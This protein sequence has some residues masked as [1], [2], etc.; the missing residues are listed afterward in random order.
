[1]LQ[2]YDVVNGSIEIIV[3][4]YDKIGQTFTKPEDGF[5]NFIS[6]CRQFIVVQYLM[7]SST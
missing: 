3:F 5:A 4:A 2:V 7:H 6:N 1:L